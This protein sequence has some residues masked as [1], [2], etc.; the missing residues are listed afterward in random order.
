MTIFDYIAI[1]IIAGSILVAMM[2][3]LVAEVLSLGSWLIAFWCAKQ[4][5][6]VVS[7]FLPG[8]LS[9]EGLRLVAGFVAVFFLAWLATALLRVTLTGML[10]SVG[11]GGVNRLFGAVFGLARGLVL[12]TALVLVGGLSDLPRQPMWRNAVLSAPFESVALSLRP[13]LPAMLA[14]NLHYTG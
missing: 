7:A 10:D 8:E 2:R 11:L 3:G 4:F 14:D 12:V 13:W 9:S 5:S 6:P 1:A